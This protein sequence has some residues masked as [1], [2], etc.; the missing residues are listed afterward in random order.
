MAPDDGDGDVA[1]RLRF[2]ILG[3]VTAWRDGT[4]LD[5]GSRQPRLMPACCSPGPAAW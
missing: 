5:L 3:H 1:S 4:E 2:T